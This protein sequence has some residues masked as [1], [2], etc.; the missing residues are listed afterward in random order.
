MRYNNYERPSYGPWNA[1]ADILGAYIQKRSIDGAMEYA[2]RQSREMDALQSANRTQAYDTDFKLPSMLNAALGYQLPNLQDM[3]WGTPFVDPRNATV[4]T[5]WLGQEQQQQQNPNYKVRQLP[6]LSYDEYSNRLQDMRS[7]AMKEMIRKY[8]VE[9]AERALGMIDQNIQSRKNTYAEKLSNQAR[10]RLS[11]TLNGADYST[12]QGIN[13]ILWNVQEYNNNMK[14]MGRDGI[15]TSILGKMLESGQVKLVTQDLGGQVKFYITGKNGT[16]LG[17]D[18]EGNPVYF[19]EIGSQ[20]K[21]VSPNTV[22]TTNA[23]NERAAANREAADNRAAA[24]RASREAIAREKNS[25]SNDAHKTMQ[26]AISRRNA[27][28]K[29][30]ERYS[31]DPANYEDQEVVE[32]GR[33]VLRPVLKPYPYQSEL[34]NLTQYIAR[35]GTDSGTPAAPDSGGSQDPMGEWIDEAYRRGYTT[36]QIRNFLIQNGKED[37]VGWLWD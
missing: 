27:L 24:N 16:S 36:D 28:E 12:P 2:D 14:R 33:T 13:N 34:D 7:T 30:Y 1:L 5:D 29:D 20:S 35:G 9:A 21:T 19:R 22:Y 11:E 15:D 6:Q 32:D 17:R 10:S 8:G 26:Q 18:E 3:A 25:G 31:Q 4:H 37:Y 23:A